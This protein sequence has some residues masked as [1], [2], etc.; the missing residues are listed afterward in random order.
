MD[1]GQIK[2][3]KPSTELELQVLSPSLNQKARK[4]LWEGTLWPVGLPNSLM[5]L[6]RLSYFS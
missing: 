6:V 5:F 1:S 2:T 4:A 3:T